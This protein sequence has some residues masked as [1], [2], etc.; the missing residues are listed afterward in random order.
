M[1]CSK[2]EQ[3]EL[4]NRPGEG[5]AVKTLRAGCPSQD[6]CRPAQTGIVT[7]GWPSNSEPAH[8]VGWEVQGKSI[9]LAE[10]FRTVPSDWPRDSEQMQLIG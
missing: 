7:P 10:K 1:R 6:A 9:R 8:L 4:R 2:G 3:T 5:T